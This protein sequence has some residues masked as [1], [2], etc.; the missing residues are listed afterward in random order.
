MAYKRSK[1]KHPRAGSDPARLDG[2]SISSPALPPAKM[3]QSVHRKNDNICSEFRKPL[4]AP[5]PRAPRLRS[6]RHP[7]EPSAA[8]LPDGPA[9]KAQ[10]RRN[11]S[12]RLAMPSVLWQ[13]APRCSD[14]LRMLQ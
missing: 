14:A 3:V 6:S 9:G 13:E 7:V 12:A 4:V 10:G 2:L 8:P 1:Q 5:C 11:G